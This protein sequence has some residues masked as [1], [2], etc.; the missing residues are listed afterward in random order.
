MTLSRSETILA[1]IKSILDAGLTGAAAATVY[2][3]R[4]E[5]IARG[6]MPR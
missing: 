3:D 6:E 5:A 2:R 4:A 1:E